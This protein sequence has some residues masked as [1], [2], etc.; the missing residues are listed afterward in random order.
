MRFFNIEY[1]A[2]NK[3]KIVTF[4]GIRIGFKIKKKNDFLKLLNVYVFDENSMQ[5]VTDKKMLPNNIHISY[6]SDN[7][8]SYQK[9]GGGNVLKIHKNFKSKGVSIIYTKDCFNSECILEDSGESSG[10]AAKILF[11]SGDG[12][13]LKIGKRSGING[14]EIWLGNGS[15]CYIGN[16][17]MFS[18]NVVIRTTDGHVILDKDTGKI[19]NE[20]RNPCV[21]GNHC[22]IGMRSLIMKNVYLPDN[23]IVG[24]G[25]VVTSKFDES[26]TVIAGNPAQVM[27]KNVVHDGRTIYEYKNL[28][29]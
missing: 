12:S 2:G 5:R 9:V 19:I 26:Y 27:K 21:I 6:H 14:A 11:L 7:A 15:E 4:L 20:Q 22:W 1:S 10:V 17:C 28:L 24:A 25:S 13:K 23:T 29:N 18:Y 8:L 3:A 16:D